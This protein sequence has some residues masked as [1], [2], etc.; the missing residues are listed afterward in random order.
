MLQIFI[1]GNSQS[2]LPDLLSEFKKW[3][4]KTEDRE[5]KETE[6]ST[7]EGERERENEE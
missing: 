3:K 1:H 5:I 7:N 2:S 6:N 4:N